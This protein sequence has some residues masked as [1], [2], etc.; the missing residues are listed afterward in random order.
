[1]MR[2]MDDIPYRE[3]DLVLARGVSYRVEK[4]LG[5]GGMGFVLMATERELNDTVVLKF[6]KHDVVLDF[7]ER[8][9]R[10][11]R[12]IRKVKDEN[13]VA[14]ER[15]GITEDRWALPFYQMEY[16]LGRPLHAVRMH[17]GG[18]ITLR[19][20]L[21]LAGQLASGLCAIHA[22]GLVHRDIKPGNILLCRPSDE[23][24]VKIIDFGIVMLADEV[25]GEPTSF[26]GTP[27]YA[28]P[29]QLQEKSCTTAVDVFAA[30]LV[31]YEV[32][33][34]VHPYEKFGRGYKNALERV[35]VPAPPLS[36]HGEF[37]PAL[38]RLLARGLE[39]APNK[40]P[41]ALKLGIE[42]KKINAALEPVSVHEAVTDPGLGDGLEAS[43]QTEVREITQADVGSPTD[44]DGSIPDWMAAMRAEHKRAAILGV[45]PT[46]LARLVPPVAPVDVDT[47]PD[48]PQF[49]N[50]TAPMGARPVT[51]TP[52]PHELV[53]DPPSDPLPEPAK[54]DRVQYAMV[55]VVAKKKNET[56]PMPASPVRTPSSPRAQAEEDA[57]PNWKLNV[58][59]IG[60]SVAVM[61][62]VIVSAVVYVRRQNT[63][64]SAPV[65]A[66]ATAP[67]G[68][69]R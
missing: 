33:T 29:E 64:P 45:E 46:E 56:T 8:F 25:A 17:A 63:A 38:T 44:P 2:K 49:L 47:Q 11:A 36:A 14:V 60:A 61:V 69:T 53:T 19:Q 20:G 58:A 43:P 50:V 51:K 16:V 57:P 3:G 55:E 27:F 24:I 54:S 9:A 13:V 1:M 37:P 52:S 68:E 32:L 6:L 41:D 48:A 39:L 26:A 12:V 22:R 5:S 31:V 18:K 34:G 23:T 28:A 42:L 10:E 65:S 62:A 66:S 40:R 15:L 67:I 30:C 4:I 21:N 59:V 7:G 35:E